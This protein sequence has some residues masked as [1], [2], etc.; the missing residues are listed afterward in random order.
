[1]GI[2]PE[3]VT[4][5]VVAL[6]S[7]DFQSRIEYKIVDASG[8]LRSSFRIDS[9]A[10][11]RRAMSSD[12]GA[13]PVEWD[14][15]DTG[16]GEGMDSGRHYDIARLGYSTDIYVR[17]KVWNVSCRRSGDGV[18]NLLV[19]VRTLDVRMLDDEGFGL[20]RAQADELLFLNEKDVERLRPRSEGYVLMKRFG[21]DRPVGGNSFELIGELDDMARRL[22]RE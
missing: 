7:D 6:P 17:N 3:V 16:G 13:V 12:T 20:S 8:S 2:T 14:V 1:M 15:F 22:L 10:G 18:E 19:S 4:K 5:K 11:E 9:S 21:I